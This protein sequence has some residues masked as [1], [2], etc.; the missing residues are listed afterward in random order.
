MKQL[1]NGTDH[2][3]KMETNKINLADTL[4]AFI[5]RQVV[6]DTAGTIV[7]LGTL[8]EVT[9][10]GFWLANADIHDCSEG[11][12]GKEV[13]VYEAKVGGVRTNRKRLLV[14]R[15]TVISL[16]AL[17]DVVHED[18]GPSSGLAV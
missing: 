8:R 6:L 3:H 12:A 14:M 11:H 1:K 2:S 7:Y 5:G 16:A 4:K 13:Y 18:L 10:T 9:Q 15:S 17:D